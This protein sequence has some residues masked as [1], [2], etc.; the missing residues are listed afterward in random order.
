MGDSEVQRS[1]R[2]AFWKLQL[3]T[4]SFEIIEK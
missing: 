1:I 2:N 4:N 3:K